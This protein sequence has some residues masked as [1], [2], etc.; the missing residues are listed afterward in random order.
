MPVMKGTGSASFSSPSDRK[1]PKSD[2][3]TD[4]VSSFE[5]KGDIGDP[6]AT[7]PNVKVG[8]GVEAAPNTEAEAGA[9]AGADAGAEDPNGEDGGD[10]LL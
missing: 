5:L 7:D 8:S 10:Y 2:D 1:E 3:E 6:D 4:P 9:D